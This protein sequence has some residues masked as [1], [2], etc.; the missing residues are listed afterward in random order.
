MSLETKIELDSWYELAKPAIPKF[1]KS[2]PEHN[3][4]IRAHEAKKFRVSGVA[5]DVVNDATLI[6][7]HRTIVLL[8]GNGNPV[9]SCQIGNVE[10]AIR[11]AKNNKRSHFKST[12]GLLTSLAPHCYYHW[13]LD[14]LPGLEVIDA[15]QDK[16]DSIDLFYI[17]HYNTDFQKD[18]LSHYGITDDR[19]L[20]TFGKSDY[21]DEKII[22]ARFDKIVVPRFRDLDG[23]WPNRWILPRLQDRFQVKPDD[24]AQQTFCSTRDSKKIYITRGNS[25][26]RVIN[27]QEIIPFLH[28]AGVEVIDMSGKSIAEQARIAASAS[29]ICGA[30]GAGLANSVFAKPGTKLIE[31]CG[32]YLSSHFRILSEIAELDYTVMDVGVDSNGNKFCTNTEKEDRH[33]DFYVDV[34]SFK[35]SLSQHLS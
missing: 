28:E 30:H 6:C 11:I 4:L 14:T 25:R 29:L 35:S 10:R 19:V 13:L 24:A 26:R 16:M 5:L 2:I 27:E 15:I 31:F 3:W 21:W 7:A 8:D 34:D 12:I 1:K 17:A 9:D 23:K 32:P 20:S 33:T 18:S 22:H